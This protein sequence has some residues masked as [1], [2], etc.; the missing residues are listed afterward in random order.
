VTKYAIES[1]DLSAGLSKGF[2]MIIRR[3]KKTR[4]RFESLMKAIIYDSTKKSNEPR[5][6]A[7]AKS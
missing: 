5:S 7:E 2:G 1:D 3:N 6:L 4:S